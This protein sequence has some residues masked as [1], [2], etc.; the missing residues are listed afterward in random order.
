[1]LRGSLR[2]P[3]AAASGCTEAPPPA[4]SWA[5]PARIPPSR[6]YRRGRRQA[7]PWARWWRQISL[8]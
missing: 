8:A 2:R 6:R 5:F 7:K 3:R 1:M 4:V